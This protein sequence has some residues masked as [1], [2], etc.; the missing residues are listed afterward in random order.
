MTPVRLGLVGAGG[1]AQAY[2]QMLA[3]GSPVDTGSVAVGVADLDGAAA[4][5]WADQVGCPSFD[6]PAALLELEPEAV[7]LCT[8]PAT[9]RELAAIF[10]RHGVPVLSEKP[11]AIDRHS[12]L[13]MVDEARLHGTFVGM[14]AKFRFCADLQ[15]AADMIIDGS[16][17]DIRLVENAFTS[18]ID[19]S[20]RWNSDPR[21]SGGGVIIDNGTHSVD[22]IAWLCGP[23]TEILAT[24]QSRPF[25]LLVEDTAR[26]QLATELGI[27]VMID[28]SWSIDKSLSDF[29]R[30]YGT[31]GE[32]RVGWQSSARRRY[33]GEWEVFGT[34]YSKL[35]SMGGALRQFCA[36]VRGEEQLLVDGYQGVQSAAVIDTAYESLRSGRWAKVDPSWTM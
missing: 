15:T 33:G 6:D 7:V 17:G 21:L 18:R 29:L 2:A 36:A 13:G 32:L 30:V 4:R 25:G 3:E 10:L 8:P 19:M 26:L 5:R 16:L 14:A 31:V 11:L 22:L 35:D 27:D 34:G 1:I 9:H 23:I 20:T 12:A 28:L 24:E